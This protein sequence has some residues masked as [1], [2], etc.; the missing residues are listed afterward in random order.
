MITDLVLLTAIVV[1][2]V[3]LSGWTGW[4]LDTLSRILHKNVVSFKPFTCSLC[5]S[6]WTGLAYLIFTGTLTIPHVALV[7]GLAF[8]TRPMAELFQTINDLL[9]RI[10][11]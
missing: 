9:I 5:M 10:I 4:L 2:I 1:F 6:W 8:L 3:D 11:Q 7:A